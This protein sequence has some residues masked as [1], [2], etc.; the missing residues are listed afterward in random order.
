M[1]RNPSK[2]NPGT[3]ATRQATPDDGQQQRQQQQQPQ[4]Q[5]GSAVNGN[6]SGNNKGKEREREDVGDGGPIATTSAAAPSAGGTST[7]ANKKEKDDQT[8][9]NALDD[10]VG[11]AGVD[12]NAEEEAIR[13]SNYGNKQGGAGQGGSG[14]AAQRPKVRP[15]LILDEQ[16]LKDVVLRIG[17]HFLLSVDIWS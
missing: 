17:E 12:L 15:R 6:A 8:D 5:G 7:G 2:G 1:S 14:Q 13:A 9:I 4:Q 10:A 11:I 16:A 3:P